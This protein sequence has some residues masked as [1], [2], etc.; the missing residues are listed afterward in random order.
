MRVLITGATGYLGTAMAESVPSGVDPILMG[1]SRGMRSLDVTDQRAV[2]AAVDRHRPESIVHLAAVSTLAGAAEDPE[3]AAA[4][5]VTGAGVVATAARSARVR[6]VALS[7]DVVFDGSSGPYDEASRPGPVNDY[8]RSKLAGEAAV[9]AAHPAALVLRTTVLVGRDRAGRHPFSAFVVERAARGESID[10]FQNERRNFFPVTR[11]AA[12]VWECAAN[13]IT[14]LLHIGAGSSAS[15]YQFGKAMLERAGFDPRLAVAVD[16]P[17]D[18]PADLTMD[19]S[20]A[21]S[22]LATP[23]P[24]VKEAIEET[25][26][27]LTMT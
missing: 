18:R 26:L 10:L 5:N 20:R 19:V 12:A 11:A 23:M 8:G 1:F 17:A 27:D 14:G 6:L 21:A 15:R 2:E 25:V 7:S 4:V 24:T 9:L 16:G 13:E 3:R 22:A